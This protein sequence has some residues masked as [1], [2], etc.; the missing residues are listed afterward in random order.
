M[1]IEAKDNLREAKYEDAEAFARIA[2]GGLL[3]FQ[4]DTKFFQRVFRGVHEASGIILEARQRWTESGGASSMEAMDKLRDSIRIETEEFF[5]DSRAAVQ[6][7]ING[8]PLAR[9]L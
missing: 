9:Q 5:Q 6:A 1:L 4:N 7:A 2:L 8:S 3:L